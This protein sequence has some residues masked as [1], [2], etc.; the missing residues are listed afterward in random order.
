MSTVSRNGAYEVLDFTSLMELKPRMPT[1]L[2][3][4]GLFSDVDYGSTTIAQV[5]RVKEGEDGIQAKARGADRNFAGREDAIQRN[6]NIPF[7]PLDSKFTAKEIQDLKAWG[8][9]DVPM[10]MQD[11]VLRSTDRVVRSHQ[12]SRA[13]A[14]YAALLGNSYS[15]GFKQAQYDYATEFGVSK[16]TFNVTF[17]DANTDPRATIETEARR[18]IIDNAQDGAGSYR[19]IALTGSAFFDALI[20]HPLVRESYSQYNSDQEPLR[21]RLGG[22]AVERTFTTQN[23]TYVEDIHPAD[24]GL[25]ADKVIFIP[26]GIEDTLK[27]HYAP[28]DTLKDANT[29]AKE[30]YL[31]MLSDG[32]RSEAVETETSMLVVNTRVELFPVGQAITS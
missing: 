25:A 8:T 1:L 26:L 6:F 2:E 10:S 7:F 18:H 22:D 13:R 16:K 9:T 14:Q 15:P 3:R 5:E 17:T 4:L 20:A 29:T 27:T 23:I 12:R 31:F 19:I 21:N 30:M 32:H 11:R 24:S 28:A